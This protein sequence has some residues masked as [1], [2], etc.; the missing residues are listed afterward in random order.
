MFGGFSCYEVLRPDIRSRW[1][2][3]H[4]L[5]F[6]QTIPLH[7]IRSWQ[8]LCTKID[9]IAF[10]R[11]FLAYFDLFFT[12]FP[13][14]NTIYFSSIFNRKCCILS[15]VDLVIGLSQ[16][17]SNFETTIQWLFQINRK[18][19]G[20]MVIPQPPSLHT[21]THSTL[22]GNREKWENITSHANTFLWKNYSIL[23]TFIPT[24]I[25]IL[26]II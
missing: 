21:N 6:P 2:S 4:V 17:T 22:T 1:S 18:Y 23:E 10:F 8:R 15:D 5:N 12:I 7:L 16:V 3:R 11:P 14:F 20:I 13:L 25:R 19:N 24:R 9:K 26:W